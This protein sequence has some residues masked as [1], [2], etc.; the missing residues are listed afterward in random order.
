MHT[1]TRTHLMNKRKFICFSKTLC[2]PMC[3]PSRALIMHTYIHVGKFTEWFLCV[4]D[5]VYIHNIRH[6][7]FMPIEIKLHIGL[8][9]MEFSPIIYR[10]ASHHHKMCSIYC[11]IFKHRD[12]FQ[13]CRGKFHI[14][15][16]QLTIDAI[17]VYARRNVWDGKWL[18]FSWN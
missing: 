9:A 18:H 6:W 11:N 12:D 7:N 13:I 15:L 1:H 5:Y 2:I 14:N 17:N 8:N 4:R 16:L 10:E 3:I